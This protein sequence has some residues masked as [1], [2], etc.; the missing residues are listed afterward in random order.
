MLL[1]FNVVKKTE[2]DE[3][4]KKVN[5]VKTADTWFN[6]KSLIWHKN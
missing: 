4:I 6:L 3:S 2:Y 1:F 5:D